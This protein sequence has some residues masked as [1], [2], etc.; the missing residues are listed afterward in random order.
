MTFDPQLDAIPVPESEPEF[1]I[2]A[3]ESPNPAATAADP[4]PPSPSAVEARLLDPAPIARNIPGRVDALHPRGGE[5]VCRRCGWDWTP[6]PDSPR[7][8]VA[9]AR[10]HSQ[11]WNYPPRTAR[12]MKPSDERTRWRESRVWKESKERSRC[13]D[14][15]FH[16]IEKLGGTSSP[17][18]Q[19]MA[20]QILGIPLESN[21]VIA[22]APSATPTAV[23][24]SQIVRPQ[25]NRPSATLP[26]R[27]AMPSDSGLPVPPPPPSW[28]GE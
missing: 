19:N 14:R 11:Y 5:Y 2:M 17:E 25:P 3:P 10:C 13:I 7:P 6:R 20:R 4:P 16:Y 22:A 12:G 21:I 9:C 18:V 26:S 1:D 23:V 27:V 28:R 24:A 15:L 8:P